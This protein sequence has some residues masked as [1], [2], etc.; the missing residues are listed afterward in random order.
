MSRWSASTAVTTATSG[1]RRRNERSN[2]SASTASRGPSPST[3]LLPKFFEMPPRKALPV[4]STSRLSHAT[5]V[6]VVV[7][8]CVPAT[9]ITYLPAER[10]PSICD[11]FSTV[12]PWSRNQLSS[13]WSSGTA[14]GVDHHGALPLAERGGNGRRVVRVVNDGSLGCERLGECRPRAVVAATL[15]PSWRK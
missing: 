15:R 5:S 12:K 4:P 1:R 3:R 9:A 13:E 6:E 7:L 10:W 2:S 8:P 11:R 14:G